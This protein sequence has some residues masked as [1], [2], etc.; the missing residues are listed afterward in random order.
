MPTGES[1]GTL[2][3]TKIPGLSDP[4]DIQAALRLYH[5]GDYAYNSANASTGS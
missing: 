4:A 5:Y 2:V 1:I 3:P